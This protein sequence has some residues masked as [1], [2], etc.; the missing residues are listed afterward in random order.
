MFTPSRAAGLEA[1]TLF[2]PSAGTVYTR[3]RNHDT[4]P[5]RDNVSGLSP[6]LRH[7]LLTEREVVSVVLEQHRFGACEKFVQEVFWRT[8]WKGWLE[9]N[10][11]VWRRYRRD[12][13]ELGLAGD[14]GSGDY[15]EAIAGLTGIDAMDA[16]V[17]E[18][19]DTGYLHNHTRMW[20]ASIWVFTLGLP[21]QLGADFFYRHLLDG[22]AA[23]NTLSW[24]WVAGLQ[25]AGKTYLATA[26]NISRYTEGRFSPSG[27]ATSARA[28]VEEPLPT[29]APIAPAES[30]P[31]GARVGLLLHEEDLDAASLSAE[32][33]WFD[34]NSRLVAIAGSADPDERSP[35][36][37]SDVVRRFTASALDDGATRALDTLGRPAK[38][39]PDT[40]PST[41]LKWAESERLDAVVVPYAPVGPVQER[42]LRLGAVL[43]SE[44]VTLTTVRRRWDTIAWPHAARGF[45]PFRER[46]PELL[47][48]QG[49]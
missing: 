15:R 7:R 49:L 39:L 22:D 43:A 46:I 33:P 47:R 18:L 23:S 25:T 32:H 34:S 29:R 44:A 20:F 14:T 2:A 35:S 24:R 12:V 40:L 45:F 26:S 41:V 38:V 10:P 17:H 9:Q 30:T 8:Y 27:L 11:E 13:V 36:G 48:Q 21:W 1:L 28:I 31:S 19:L 4:G 42:M 37:A 16:W 5:S 3:D 6:Y